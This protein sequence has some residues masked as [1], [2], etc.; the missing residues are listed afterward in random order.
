MPY[1][2]THTC[3]DPVIPFSVGKLTKSSVSGEIINEDQVLEYDLMQRGKKNLKKVGSSTPVFERT[4]DRAGRAMSIKYLAGSPS[5]KVFSYEY[6]VDGNILYV[7]DN[8]TGVHLAD[9][10]DF[11]ALG[12]SRTADYPKSGGVSIKRTYAYDPVTARLTSAFTQKY[13]GG[14]LVDTYKKLEYQYDPMGNPLQVH[15]DPN[16]TPPVN[17]VYNYDAIGNII[18]KTDVGSYTYNYGNRP[19]AVNSAGNISLQYDLNGNMTQRS[20]SGGD[21]LNITYNYDNKP[22]IIQKNGNNF[23]GFTY[24]G[25]GNRVKKHNYAIG[26]DVV[27]FGGLYEERSGVGIIHVYA[28][29]ERVASFRTDGNS[30][31]YYD[32]HLGSATIVTDQTGARKERLEYYPFGTYSETRDDDPNFP[33]VSYTFTDQEE[34]LEIG[35]YNFRARLYDPVLG[36]FVTPDSIVPDPAD[37]QSLNRYSYVANNPLVYT[38][39]SGYEPF[40]IAIIVGAVIGALIAGIQSKWNP[41]AMAVGAVIGGVSGGVYSGVS[42]V[43]SGSIASSTIAGAAGGAA[44]GATAGGMSA[45]YYGGN[46]G[47]EMLRGA[48]LGAL[49][50]AAFGAIGG[51][52]GETWDLGRVGAY[53]LAGG[54]ISQL[55]GQ[56]F[57]KGA[58]FAGLTSFARYTY[59]EIVGYDATW[60]GG[61]GYQ[62]KGRYTLPREGFCHIGGQGIDP[63]GS[64]WHDLPLEGSALSRGANYI[65]SV[66]ATAG[67]HDVMQIKLDQFFGGIGGESFGASMR[68][69]LNYPGMIPAAALTT[70]GLLADPRAMMLFAIDPTCNR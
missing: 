13:A 18:F 70:T 46:I 54:G 22:D 60:E 28:G 11:T 58:L 25:S 52:Y 24:N 14:T 49:G 62:E 47:M 16:L 67:L 68:G 36:K 38:D 8:A 26:Q 69:V 34:D 35:L 7:K 32:N 55:S 21:T 31:Y 4:F 37:P 19:H 29:G 2:N 57:E 23:I 48:G 6:D 12:Q 56:G 40:T 27:Y 61:E 59:N 1:A 44:A 17:L 9:Y 30:Q 63:N 51:Y 64:L 20:V 53:T 3:D 42:G 5:E 65:L 10:S 15:D 43:V 41:Q 45:A 50:G 39:P 33:N 66:N